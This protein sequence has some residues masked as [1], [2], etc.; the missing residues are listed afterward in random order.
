MNRT[1]TPPSCPCYHPGSRV[2][3]TR[4][5]SPGMQD[6]SQDIIPMHC[7]SC[8][9]SWLH[10]YPEYHAFGHVGRYYRLRPGRTRDG[11]KPRR[12]T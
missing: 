6:G 8:G 3:W 7:A 12:K 1:A 11:H 10:I 9:T 4:Q 2:K 5:P